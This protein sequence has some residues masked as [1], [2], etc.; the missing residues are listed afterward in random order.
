[1]TKTLAKRATAVGRDGGASAATAAV[2]ITSA[3]R[4]WAY[5]W[6][7]AATM[8]L[9]P[10]HIAATTSASARFCFSTISIHRS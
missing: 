1:M 5:Q 6:I 10:R 7:A 9:M 3:A 2:S 4:Q 8:M